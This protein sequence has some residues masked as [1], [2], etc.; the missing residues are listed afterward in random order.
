MRRSSLHI[1]TETDR[2][3]AN[4]AF[5]QRASNIAILLAAVTKG[6]DE[7][8]AAVKGK[9]WGHIG[10]LAAVEEALAQAAQS[11]NILNDD[12]TPDLM[13]HYGF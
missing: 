3:A 5:D 11:L 1:T 7:K 2:R 9:G 13:A 8:K 4:R 12:D 6:I 10:D